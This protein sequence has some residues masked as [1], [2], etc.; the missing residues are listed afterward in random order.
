MKNLTALALI[1]AATY[2]TDQPEIAKGAPINSV[3][4]ELADK[5][6]A[7]GVAKLA[8]PE[9][10]R[11]ASKKL[12]VRVLVDCSLGRCNDVAEIDAGALKAAEDAGLVD[13]DKAAV[14]YALT[15]DQNKPKKGKADDAL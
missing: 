12:Q 15:L 2:G 6:I 1:A 4:D 13:S 9:N 5:M 7:D 14:A 3:P 11:K 10:T 8:E